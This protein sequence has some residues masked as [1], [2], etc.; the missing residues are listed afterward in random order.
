MVFR[1]RNEGVLLHYSSFQD[2]SNL[3][4]STIVVTY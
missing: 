4:Y 3:I 1:G 2:I